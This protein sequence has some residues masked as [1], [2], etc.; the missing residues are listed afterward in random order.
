[1]SVIATLA[2]VSLVL[3]NFT[4]TTTGPT[5][6]PSQLAFIGAVSL[7]L[8]GLFVYVQTVRHRDDFVIAYAGAVTGQPPRSRTVAISA[9][10]LI[11][12]LAVVIALAKTLSPVL[13]RGVVL[14]GLPLAVVG[15]V[16]AMLVLLPEGITAL[17]AA[18]HNKLQTSLNAS[19]GSAAASIGLTIPVV[20]A[21]SVLLGQPLT[22]GLGA[23][24]MVLLLLTLF[25]STLTFATGR[26]TIL[27][28][29]VHL[30]IFAVFLFLSAVP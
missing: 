6:A 24:D 19:L 20:G 17:K 4:L 28:G 15:V 5:F 9:V 26:T 30:V 2:I 11:A 23:E 8:Y 18:R 21:T 14:A 3:P 29:A 12:S 27:Q 16:I 13:E 10:L 1:L 25:V 7:G 22:L